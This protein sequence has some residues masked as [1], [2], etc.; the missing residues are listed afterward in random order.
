MF[1]NNDN[2]PPFDDI[3]WHKMISACQCAFKNSFIQ[4][5]NA[6]VICLQETGLKNDQMTLKGYVYYHKSGKLNRWYE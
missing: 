4:K 6:P 2:G 5:Y 3:L 1:F